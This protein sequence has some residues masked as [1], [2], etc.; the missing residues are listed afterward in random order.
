MT[1]LVGNDPILVP[2]LALLLA[3]P[4]Y[5]EIHF[6]LPGIPGRLFQREPELIFD[7]PFRTVAGEPV[8]LFLFVKDAD[9]YPV[10]IHGVEV[11]VEAENGKIRTHRFPFQKEIRQP[12]FWTA[13]QLPDSLFAGGCRFLVTAA[14]N[15]SCR[16]KIKRLFQDNYRGI[17]HPPFQLEIGSPLPSDGNWYWGDMHVHSNY[18]A[19]EIEFGAP[20]E[21]ALLAAQSLGLHFLAITDHSYDFD[22]NGLVN[23]AK[24]IHAPKWDQFQ[25][26]IRRL[27][28]RYPEFVLLAGEEVSAGNSRGGNVH[29][30]VVGNSGFIPGDGDGKIALPGARPSLS[31]SDIGVLRSRESISIAAHPLETPPLS[32]R[33]L[34][35]RD[36]WYWEDLT[37]RDVDYWQILNGEMNMLFYQ[38]MELWKEALLQGRRVGLVAGND[39]HGNF[40]CFRQIR[41]PFLKMVRE[42]YH[43]M[44][45]VRTALCIDGA[46]TSH[47]VQSALRKKRVIISDGPFG[48]VQIRGPEGRCYLLGSTVPAHVENQIIIRAISSPDY[49]ELEEI[50]LLAGNSQTGSEKETKWKSPGGYRWIKNLQ[51]PLSEQIGYIRLEVGTKKGSRSYQAFSNP[52][53][54]ST[55]N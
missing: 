50:R 40:N 30:L 42:N 55:I 26:E 19:D 31:I 38:G 51:L 41:I 21:A 52:I 20:A 32:Q 5:A 39:A 14:L 53:W 3:V 12:F 23:P 47:S 11:T 13:F 4:A 25:A 9:D 24:N 33:L 16:G 7:L 18:T 17:P 2:L 34:L 54:F 28:Q 43:L 29:Y 37:H 8:P 44:G 6:R 45:R 1:H 35:R 49:G 22:W 48:D 27:N 10:Q 46:V 36:R 15:Y